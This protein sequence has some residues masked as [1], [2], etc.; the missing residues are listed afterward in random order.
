[1]RPKFCL[2]SLKIRGPQGR[3][4]PRCTKVLKPAATQ[5]HR[6]DPSDGTNRVPGTWFKNRNPCSRDEPYETH[7]GDRYR[8]I[9]FTASTDLV[10]LGQSGHVLD[11]HTRRYPYSGTAPS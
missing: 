5:S 1:M 3:P 2:L 7:F 10:R 4:Y 6:C 9:P 8:A 11:P